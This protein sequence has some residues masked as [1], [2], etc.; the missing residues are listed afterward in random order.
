MTPVGKIFENSHTCARKTARSNSYHARCG[1]SS[2]LTDEDDV[3]RRRR[4]GGGGRR[5]VL[6]DDRRGA[7]GFVAAFAGGEDVLALTPAGGGRLGIAFFA[8]GRPAA[9]QQRLG[10]PENRVLS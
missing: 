8:L 2:P 7:D 6:E 4:G 1:G 3:E 5:A 9:N 10:Q